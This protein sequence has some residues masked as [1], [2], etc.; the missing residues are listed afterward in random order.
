MARLEPG[1]R[2]LCIKDTQIFNSEGELV[3]ERN[4]IAGKE[5]EVLKSGSDRYILS[6]KKK[7][8]YIGANSEEEW[9]KEHFIVIDKER[10]FEF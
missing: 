1:M 7:N 3:I 9:F 2:I 10:I 8:H 5:Y 4:E 6:E